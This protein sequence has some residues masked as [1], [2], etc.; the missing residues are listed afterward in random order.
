MSEPETI[1]T[2][3]PEQGSDIQHEVCG[4][5][6]VSASRAVSELEEKAQ[7]PR[8]KEVAQATLSVIGDVSVA[9]SDASSALGEAPRETKWKPVLLCTALVYMGSLGFAWLL[10][11]SAL[12]ARVLFIPLFPVLCTGAAFW[13]RQKWKFRAKDWQYKL[14]IWQDALDS[15]SHETVNTVNAVRAQLI[16]FRLANPKVSFPEHLDIIQ[17][18]TLRVDTII[19]KAQDPVKWHLSKKKKKPKEEQTASQVGEDTRSRIAL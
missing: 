7:Q 15:V 17:E 19:Q 16:G 6:G 1:Q 5:T 10:A 2:Q 3:A 11:R 14:K 18:E 12:W 8:K 9:A 4:F 13:W